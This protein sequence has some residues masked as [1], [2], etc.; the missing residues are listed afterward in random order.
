MC[1]LTF[2]CVS[3][4]VDRAFKLGPKE[5]SVFVK[6]MREYEAF[7]GVEVLSYC[8][9]SNHVHLLV[10]VPKL[11]QA[12]EIDDDLLL[13]RLAVLYKP[14]EVTLVAKALAK[15]RKN[16]ATKAARELRER[17]SYW[18]GDISVFMKSLKQ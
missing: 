4:V 17:Y 8:V 6:M 15:Y 13:E 12:E 3:R 7:C 10:R 9:M 11:H 16:H 14:A 1:D 2:H 18:M 5:K